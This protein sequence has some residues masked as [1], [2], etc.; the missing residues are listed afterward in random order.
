MIL[1]GIYLLCQEQYLDVFYVTVR[2]R[3]HPLK[4]V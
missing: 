4:Q 3:M 1:Y 2:H